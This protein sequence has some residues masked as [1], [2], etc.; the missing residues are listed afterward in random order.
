MRSVLRASTFS[1]LKLLEIVIVLIYYTINP[2]WIYIVKALSGHHFQLQLLKP[3][4]R[5][6]AKDY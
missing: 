1:V 3:R 6:L 4:L 2:F 5:C